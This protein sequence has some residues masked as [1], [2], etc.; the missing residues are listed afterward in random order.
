MDPDVCHL[1]LGF[2]AVDLGGGFGTVTIFV[3]V[4]ASITF[5][6]AYG[7]FVE[8]AATG[9]RAMRPQYCS[10]YEP[11]FWW[12]ERFWKLSGHQPRNLNGTP[13][14]TLTWRL[15]GLRIGKRVYDDG[16]TIHEPTLVSNGDDCTINGGGTILQSHSMEDGI[17]KSD[18]I[19]VGAGW[20]VG[21]HA[22][23]HYGVTMGPAPYQAPTASL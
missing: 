20:T 5:N 14:K 17:F 10:I 6:V 11:Y 23:V 4:V 15:V 12:Y 22:F 1:L 18:H 8:G 16:C 21:P 9:F 13:F 7:L 2:A 19:N 3:A